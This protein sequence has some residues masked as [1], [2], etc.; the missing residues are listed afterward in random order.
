VV[1]YFVLSIV[2]LTGVIALPK[3]EFLPYLGLVVGVF[4][5]GMMLYTFFELV[6][7]PSRVCI[8]NN[9]VE[10]QRGKNTAWQV[11]KE[12]IDSVYVSEVVNRKGKKRVIYHGEIN[13]HLKDGSFR[14]VLEQPHTIEEDHA[15]VAAMVEDSVTPLTLYN[16]Y[17]DLQMAGLHVAQ[18]LGIECQY[19]QRVK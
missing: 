15:P 18:T 13:L 7:R 12:S 4:L 3:P 5:I 19:D 8:D 10:G 16:A 9:G 1:A 14:N 11:P 2:T 17:T 6:S